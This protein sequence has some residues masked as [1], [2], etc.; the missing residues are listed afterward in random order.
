MMK[1]SFFLAAMLALCG[2]GF[3]QDIDGNSYGELQNISDDFGGENMQDAVGDYDLGDN[4]Y[5]A[6][7]K[8]G[9]RPGS[10][11]ILPDCRARTSCV[12]NYKAWSVQV[13]RCPSS[14]ICSKRSGRCIW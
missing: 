3:A 8:R 13:C 6:V 9:R 4:L 2:A 7:E 1:T 11:V 10:V 5:T 12:R 14:L